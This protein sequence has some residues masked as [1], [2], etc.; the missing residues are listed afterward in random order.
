VSSERSLSF[1]PLYQVAFSFHDAPI[2]DLRLGPQTVLEPLGAISNGTAKFDI[3]VI[4]IPRS[5]QAVQFRDMRDRRIT[6]NWEYDSALYDRETMRRMAS[7]YETLLAS[8][9]SGDLTRRLSELS[10]IGDAERRDLL[11][12]WNPV[13]SPYPETDVVDRFDE[14]AGAQPNAIAVSD[15][16][17]QMTYAELRIASTRVAAG[18]IARNAASS[19][20][21]ALLLDRSIDM[22]VATLGVLRAGAAYVPID[23][24]NPEARVSSI[25]GDADVAGVITSRDNREIAKSYTLWTLEDLL[26]TSPALEA[27]P[28]RRSLE[29][30]AYVMYTSGTTGTPKGIEVTDRNIMRLV[31]DTNYVCIGPHD[32]VGHAANV[33]FDGAT[34]EIWGALLNGGTI[35][36][37]DKKTLIDPDQ[38]ACAIRRRRIDV[39]FL[40]TAVFNNTIALEPTAFSSLRTL[41]F[42]GEAVHVA[43]VR[44]CLAEGA[45]S[46]LLH[47]YG[48]TESTAFAT[49]HCVTLVGDDEATVP[50]GK[51]IANT[52]AY[53]L[54]QAGRL[55]PVG[56]IGEL[57]LGGDGIARGYRNDT[58]RTASHFTAD[59]FLDGGRLY[60]TGDLVRRRWDGAL[61]FVGR[62]D[63]QMKIRGNRIEPGD[64]ESSLRKID[65]V[66]DVVVAVQENREGERAIVA[67][68]STWTDLSVTEIDRLARELLPAHMVP[69]RVRRVNGFA[70]NANGKIDRL[71]LPTFEETDSADSNVRQAQ[72]ESDPFGEA[73]RAIWVDLLG[74]PNLSPESEFFRSGGH[75]L[76]ATR[77]IARLRSYFDIEL[78][79]RTIFEQPTLAGFT[80]LVRAMAD[81]DTL[82]PVARRL[83]EF[84]NQDDERLEQLLSEA[85]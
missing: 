70:L 40:T 54:D 66:R 6:V 39:L 56:T 55:S 26:A 4:C 30:L 10:M 2:P 51:P 23:V 21:V 60:R 27:A 34:F 75:S 61:V 41:L 38:L 79:L 33:A 73:V 16:C 83:L 76:M 13:P 29:S 46:T 69:S 80:R 24:A 22:I 68:V 9:V 52:K 74:D 11:A 25:L 1:S 81:E 64:V 67:Y 15:G 8:F 5:E 45:P 62:S 50:I 31:C 42:G 44:R 84:L 3:N 17:R 47:V 32:R 20:R 14:C 48:P 65:G 58:E 53:V 49:F 7:Q 18:L 85:R 12:A 71:T 19:E 63:S 36:I 78:P 43:S 72:A 77:M 57:Y 37:I 82:E 28:S 59:P 35:E